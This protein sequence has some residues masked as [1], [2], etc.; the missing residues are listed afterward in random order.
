MIR[1]DHVNFAYSDTDALVLDD[2][3]LTIPTGAFVAVVGDN[4][5]GKSTFCKLLNGIIPHFID[6]ELAGTIVIDYQDISKLK[7]S[8]LAHKLVMSTRTLKIKYCDPKS[9]TT[10]PL[11][12]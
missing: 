8:H 3:S 11:V 4:G 9:S 1:L 12:Y 7:P 2:I 6:G 10:L 5:A